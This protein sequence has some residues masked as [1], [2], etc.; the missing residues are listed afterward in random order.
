MKRQQLVRSAPITGP[1]GIARLSGFMCIAVGM[2]APAL[3]Q[4]TRSWQQPVAPLTGQAVAS[5]EWDPDGAG[6]LG[7][8]LIFS[9]Y[10]FSTRAWTG[11]GTRVNAW[12]GKS[13]AAS[14]WTSMDANIVS[15]YVY[16][17]TTDASGQ[18]F[19][20]GQFVVNHNGTNTSTLAARWNGSAWIPLVVAGQTS[21]RAAGAILVRTN[22]DVIIGGDF[23]IAAPVTV[24]SNIARWDGQTW[25]SMGG[26]ASSDAP[27]SALAET[28]DGRVI[29][30]GS[31]TSIGG[32]PAANIAAWDGTSWSPLGVGIPGNSWVY[33]IAIGPDHAI[34]AGGSFNSLGAQIGQTVAKWNGTAWTWLTTAT[35]NQ[36]VGDVAFLPDGSLLAVGLFTMIDGVSA[37]R[38]ARYDGNAWSPVGTGIAGTWPTH[39]LNSLTVRRDGDFVVTTSFPAGNNPNVRIYASPCQCPAD[40]DSDGDFANGNTRD[41]A[42]DI[43]DF[44]YFLV[45]FEMG[46]VLVDLDSDGDPIAGTPDDAVDINDL[47]YFLTRFEQGC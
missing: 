30:G 11:L 4:C 6:P 21:V 25:H 17:F 24:I 45:G 7:P 23:A 28:P 34:I 5:A 8:V 2:A 38:I 43:N 29:A 39:G 32:V 13:G 3:A 20:A 16:A 41:N 35:T 46:D 14:V 12:N 10:P 15:G 31:F 19:A 18:L 44:L 33:S 22:G 1:L 27:I 47:L 42:V 26:E 37:A 40:L 9:G 36:A